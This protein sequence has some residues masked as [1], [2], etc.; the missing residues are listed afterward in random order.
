MRFI[1][2][3]GII[4]VLA[5]LCFAQAP[6][7]HGPTCGEMG[8]H[9]PA[10]Y[11][12]RP[13]VLIPEGEFEMGNHFY[14]EA[15]FSNEVPLHD[16]YIESFYMDVYEVTNQEYC[17]YLNSALSQDII[18][19]ISYKVHK[20][21]VSDLFYCK[22]ALDPLEA[23]RI[24]WNGH[25]FNITPTK[26]NH[27]ITNVTW[28]GAVA[29]ANWRSEQEGLT[30]C[31]D[32]ETWRC[33]FGVGGYRLPTEAEWEYAARGGE[34]NPYYLFPWGNDYDGSKANYSSSGDPYEGSSWPSTTPV[35][36]YDGNQIP[37][38]VDMSNGYGLYDM[39]GNV[40]EMC[41][42][43]YHS[44]YYEVSPYDNPKG[45]RRSTHGRSLRGGSCWSALV[46]VRCAYR[47]SCS[48][49]WSMFEI[50]FRLARETL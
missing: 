40:E 38:G 30:P 25:N 48:L 26:E 28:Y 44:N 7:Y 27:P 1:L 32:L 45:P 46:Q 33:N 21:G 8:W 13:M 5:F 36:Y 11:E 14:R 12:P 16:V 19:V 17:T 42:D 4:A 3:I 22:V 43:W 23:S 6:S 35:G 20:K 10:S 29:Y 39:A 47:Y 2:C 18:E 15:G 31:Y 24:I 37:H 34:H 41:N 9:P 50:G 49:E